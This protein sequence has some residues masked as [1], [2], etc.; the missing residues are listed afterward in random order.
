MNPVRPLL[1][2][3]EPFVLTLLATVA[4]GTFL[5]A[6]G[7]WR[8]V[9]GVV[10]DSAIVLLFFLQGAKL[11]REAIVGAVTHWRLHL[12]T[13]AVT[14]TVFPA[15]GW[16]LAR[17]G[18]LDSRLA[19]GILFL[20]LLPSTVQ[21]SIAFTAMARGNVAAAVCGASFS[22]LIGIVATPLLVTWLIAPAHS[23]GSGGQI[24]QSI[25]LQLLV[26]FLAGHVLRPWIG[27]FVSRHKTMVGLVDRGSILLV[28]YSAFGAAVLEGIWSQVSV[29][30]LLV[31]GLIC[32]AE[33]A[34]IL[35]ITTLLGR[36]LGFAAED[37]AVLL[38]CG[39]KK[40]LASGVPIAGVLFP[41]SGLG[42]VVLP[43]MMFHQ[44]QLIACAMIAR[45]LGERDERL[46]KAADARQDGAATYA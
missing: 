38:F 12:A 44:I 45:S 8:E 9:V 30:D 10:A 46:A 41:A 18:L 13:L 42:M 15:V 35:A 14:F 2:F 31:L 29:S 32:T 16:T 43:L 19:I 23:A 4:L 17:T 3:I 25:V 40:S 6:T 36:W 11:S 20:S 24:A 34:I 37:R 5:P 21:S 7:I 28:V 1:A 27:P 39:S 22:N 33:L 26:P